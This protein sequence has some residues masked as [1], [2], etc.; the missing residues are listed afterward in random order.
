MGLFD[1]IP[2]KFINH[3]NFYLLGLAVIIAGVVWSN[4]LMSLG[5]LILLFNYLL[6]F[7]FSRKFKELKSQKLILVLLSLPLAHFVGLI[8]TSDFGYAQKDILNKAILITLPIIIGTNKRLNQKELKALIG[9]YLSTVL[10]L[11]IFSLAKFLGYWGETI[12]DKRDLSILISH[13]RYGLNFA[14]AI[15]LIFYLFKKF[16]SFFKT[17]LTSLSIWFI[18]CLFLFELTT[19]LVCLM[20]AISSVIAIRLWS[21]RTKFVYKLSLLVLAVILCLGVVWEI[22]QVYNGYYQAIELDYDQDNYKVKTLQ[23]KRYYHNKESDLKVNG[24]YLWR[25]I[26]GD[27]LEVE[28]NKRSSINYDSLDRKGQPLTHTLVRFLSSRGFKKDSAGISNLTDADI[29]AIENGVANAYYL[30][31]NPIQNRIHRT[32]YEFENY[33]ESGVIN[34]FSLIMRYEYWKNTWSIIKENPALGVG[35]GDIKD[36][37]KK[38]YD[39]R[40]SQLTEK[41]RKRTHNQ[42]LTIWGTLGT[43]GLLVFLVYLIYPV[44]LVDKT[45][46]RLYFIFFVIAALSYITEDTLETQAGVTFIALFN[47]LILLGFPT[48]K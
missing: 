45:N 1:H 12:I 20:A 32:I 22:K 15:V 25:F 48:K 42:Y 9:I 3:R 46:R 31:H 7:D 16:N 21:H 38:A 47:S 39:N 6:E 27:E 5:N 17:I 29:T 2:V 19:G 35:T 30:Y 4:F 34:G 40:N 26:Q 28:W 14:M 13:I 37:I 24:V 36:E 10:I 11:S 33:K 41:F 43:F 44:F 8:W 18:A 23:G